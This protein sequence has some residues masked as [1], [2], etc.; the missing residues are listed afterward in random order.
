MLHRSV[1]SNVKFK[2]DSSANEVVYRD[3][4]LLA[5][6]IWSDMVTKAPVYYPPDVLRKYATNW[7]ST[8]LKVNHSPNVED[9]IGYIDNIRWNE[10]E[11]AVVGDLHIHLLT[12]KSRDVVKLIENGFVDGISVNMLTKDIWNHQLRCREVAYLE[13]WG[14]DVVT[15][16]ACKKARIKHGRKN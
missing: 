9:I 16:P 11:Q 8:L 5:A 14:A 3:V 6:G 7:K 15:D 1:F 10:R 2:S 4:I 13:F 12:Q